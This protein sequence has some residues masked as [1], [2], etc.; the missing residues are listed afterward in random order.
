MVDKVPNKS[1]NDN[2]IQNVEKPTVHEEMYCLLNVITDLQPLNDI[3]I[4]PVKKTSGIKRIH[5]KLRNVS[6]RIAF[7][8][9]YC[10]FKNPSIYMIY[11]SKCGRLKKAI[12]E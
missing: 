12:N 3:F 8:C 2:N 10:G 7:I 1:T 4:K 11:C 9:N 6:Y 5:S